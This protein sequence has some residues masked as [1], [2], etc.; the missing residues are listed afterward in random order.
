EA[1]LAE[2]GTEEGLPLVIRAVAAVSAAVPGGNVP[3]WVVV[4]A[5]AREQLRALLARAPGASPSEE[6]VVVRREGGEAVVVAA[7]TGDTLRT[8]RVSA[9]GDSLAA[10]AARG[11]DGAREEVDDRG[12]ASFGALRRVSGTDW[13]LLVRRD[14]EE[15]YRPLRRRLAGIALF[16]LALLAAAA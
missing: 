2:P 16:N 9:L 10:R 4:G 12:V 6:A 14:A 1:L 5:P 7:E 3:G 8:R 13:T 11:E 15:A